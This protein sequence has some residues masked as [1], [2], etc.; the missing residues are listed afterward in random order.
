MN[1]VADKADMKALVEG[2]LTV[3]DS[4]PDFILHD[5]DGNAV[6]LYSLLRARHVVVVFDRGSGCPY[7]DLYLRGFQRHL[8][9]LHELGAQ[10]V[11][12]SA[13]PDD[14]LFAGIKRT[15]AL[16]VLIDRDDKVIRQFGLT[17]QCS[18][19][20]HKLYRLFGHRLEDAD[21]QAGKIDVPVP[22]TFLIS[23]NGIVRL[24]H[25]DVVH[26]CRLDV[27]DIIEALRS[28]HRDPFIREN[29]NEKYLYDE[30]ND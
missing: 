5:I 24:A 20:L 10:V 28:L 21:D 22:G 9:E 6:R 8:T 11:V 15:L 1:T 12:I 3:G 16:T 13:E 25:S 18:D 4:A 7:C 2:R 23:S 29:A 30:P 26:M 17:V 19:D 27:G 14:V